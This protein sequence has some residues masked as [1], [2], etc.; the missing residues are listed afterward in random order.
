MY[1]HLTQ[2]VLNLFNI[3][4]PNVAF[5]RNLTRAPNEGLVYIV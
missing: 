2:K 1:P 4:S 3:N 5:S